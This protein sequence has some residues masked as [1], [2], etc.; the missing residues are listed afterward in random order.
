MTKSKCQNK[1]QYLNTPIS[2]SRYPNILIS[3]FRICALCLFW[4]LCF[5][6]CHSTYAQDKIVA[7][8]NNDVI[9]QR[10]LDDFINFMRMQLQADYKGQE[11]ESKIQAM[12]LDLLDRL[13]EDLLILQQA[14]KSNLKIDEGLIKDRIAQI[15]KHYTSDAE[16][17]H[18]LSQQ[19][20]TQSDIESKLNEQLLMHNIIDLE[21][22]TKLVVKPVEVTD[23]YQ[24]NREEFKL[25]QQRQV[26]SITVNDENKALAIFNALN[27][28]KSLSDI[29]NKYSL[30][31]DKLIV[32]QDGKLKKD[33]ENAIFKLNINEVSKPIKINDSFY[34]FRLDNIIAPRQPSLSEVQE[35]IYA[36]LFDKKMQEGLMRWLDELKAQSYIKILQD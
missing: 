34:I 18:A 35:R 24:K 14:K 25:P 10:D 16:F 6:I 33:I 11:L 3:L 13:I 32:R 36:F 12:K 8:V 9:T 4:I 23:F 2:K 22:K 19:G 26:S 17:Q 20:L 27:E 28:S 21:I 1:S 7:I 30:V 5:G 31:V 29:V 15:K